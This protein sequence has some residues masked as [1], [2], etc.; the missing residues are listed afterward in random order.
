MTY[1]LL[2]DSLIINRKQVLCGIIVE[3]R[4]CYFILEVGMGG[5][6]MPPAVLQNYIRRIFAI[7]VFVSCFSLHIHMFI[8]KTN[9][10]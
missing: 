1:C 10:D 7:L 5:L 3:S 6:L 4:D 8:E 9:G 2:H